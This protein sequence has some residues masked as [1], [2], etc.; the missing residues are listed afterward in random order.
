MLKQL[1]T[2]SLCLQSGFYGEHAEITSDAGLIF[3]SFEKHAS[4]NGSGLVFPQ[5]KDGSIRSCF[6]FGCEGLRIGSLSVE[7]IGLGRPTEPG[8]FS[9]VGGINELR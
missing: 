2:Q 5:T 8:S 9:A 6:E 4:D 1:F 7:N 3:E